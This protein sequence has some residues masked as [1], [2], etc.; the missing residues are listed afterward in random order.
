MVL[1]DQRKY[2][3][4]LHHVL[5]YVLVTYHHPHCHLSRHHSFIMHMYWAG[6]SIYSVA[7]VFFPV[8]SGDLWSYVLLLDAAHP[9]LL[10][11]PTVPH[12]FVG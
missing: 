9:H 5:S 11:H 4:Y 3:N 6:T 2:L 7:C 10:C 12:S 1:I 8:S